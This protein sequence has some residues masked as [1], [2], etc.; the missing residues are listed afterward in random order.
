MTEALKLLRPTLPAPVE[1]QLN[2]HP[3]APRILGDATAIHQVLMNLTT[4]AA[5]AMPGGGTI[6]VK[7]E[8]F[9]VRDSVARARPDLHEGTYALL[10]VRDT[11]PGMDPTV[12][13]RAFEPFFTTKPL[14]QGTGLGLA[15]VHG[16]MKEHGG[17]VELESELGEGTTVRCLFPALLTDEEVETAIE[18]VPSRG[19]G[20][21]VLL[22]EDER[23][24]GAVAERHL[25]ALGYAAV[26][27][28][29][30][31][32][33]LERFRASP[34]DFDLIITD[35][36]MPRLMGIELVR[37]VRAIRGDIPVVM[38]TGFIEDELAEQAAAIGVRQ[39]LRKPVPLSELAEAIR[40]ALEP[41]DIA[42]RHGGSAT[43]P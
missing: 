35:Y 22:V 19:G 23:P 41:P 18:E 15:V 33:A 17:T 37:S 8:P 29:D 31:V 20:E 9:Y 1:I 43:G 21:R 27:E 7:V 10:S 28:T 14:G 30:P 36:S 24:L 3:E 38:I 32:K 11:G 26:V 13:E 25:A 40:I 5:Y 4:N 34:N 2:V 12:K 16:V 39:L 6:D 42:A